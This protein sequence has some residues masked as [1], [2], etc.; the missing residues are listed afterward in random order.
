[1]NRITSIKAKA[2]LTRG[3][4]IDTTNVTYQWYKKDTSISTDQGGGIGWL[5]L[6]S[7]SPETGYNTDTLTI[8]S[9]AINIFEVYKC[10]IKDTQT[11][12]ITY[13]T[14]FESMVSVTNSVLPIEVRVEVDGRVILNGQG[15]KAIR[16]RLYQGGK[17]I[18]TE[19]TLYTYRWY[20]WLENATKDTSWNTTG[21]KAGKN[22]VI[23]DADV[24]TKA[25]FTV[26]V[27]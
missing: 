4:I 16:A 24:D 26:E 23:T 5:K 7:T 18:D 2:E 12:S 25:T 14:S 11:D 19:G 8:P 21:Y 3:S 15:Q 22:I 13:N 17:E 9:S 27:L 1:M 10:I 6:I 20:R